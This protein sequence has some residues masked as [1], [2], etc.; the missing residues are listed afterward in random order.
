MVVFS[1]RRAGGGAELWVSFT[2][3]RAIVRAAAEAARVAA[4]D[5]WE[6]ELVRWLELRAETAPGIDV[7]EIAWTPDHFER[8]R[9]FV[10]DALERAARSGQ[11][12]PALLR[13]AALVDAHSQAFVQFGR[14]W[15][16]SVTV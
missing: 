1:D 4:E 14:R 5:R 7:G 6:R 12:A 13:W 3:A 9:R 10:V 11:H 2:A 8:Q 15:S 16:W